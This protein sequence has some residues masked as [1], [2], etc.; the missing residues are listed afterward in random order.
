MTI[1]AKRIAVAA[2]DTSFGKM[3]AAAGLSCSMNR[4]L[5]PVRTPSSSPTEDVA[6]TSRSSD[7]S[8]S[9]WIL[10]PRTITAIEYFSHVERCDGMLRTFDAGQ[11][12]PV[13]RNWKTIGIRN[14]ARSDGPF[15]PKKAS[16]TTTVISGVFGP[17]SKRVLSC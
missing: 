16:T 10:I 7:R 14:S 8:S 11:H 4:S 1:S 13:L 3:A 12:G 6:G 5:F 15:R 2:L 9:V 17:F